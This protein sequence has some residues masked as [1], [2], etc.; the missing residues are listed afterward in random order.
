MN[1]YKVSVVR[2]SDLYNILRDAELVPENCG[3][4]IIEMRVGEAVK[5]HCQSYPDER[6]LPALQAFVKAAKVKPGEI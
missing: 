5:I 1:T 2:S 4:V 6:I 3:D